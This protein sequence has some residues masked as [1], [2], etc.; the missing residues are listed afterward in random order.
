MAMIEATTVDTVEQRLA[1]WAAWLRGGSKG[2]GYPVTNVLHE[3]WLPPAPGQMPTMMAGGF[4]TRRERQ[5]HRCVQALSVRLQNTLVVV[6]VL[7]ATGVDQARMLQCE[8]ST[9]RARVAQ[10]KKLLADMLA[11]T[12]AA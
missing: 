6:F 9:V 4:S 8:G 10:A 2:I 1:S 11:S 12:G 3:S 7:R 5:L